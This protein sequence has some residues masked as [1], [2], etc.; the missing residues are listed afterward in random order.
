MLISPGNDL[1]EYE[2]D[3]FNIRRLIYVDEINGVGS[4][5]PIVWIVEGKSEDVMTAEFGFGIDQEAMA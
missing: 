1:I 3:L 5:S 4:L 2:D